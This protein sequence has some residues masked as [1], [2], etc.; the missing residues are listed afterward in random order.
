[1]LS[2]LEKYAEADAVLASALGETSLLEQGPLLRT[3]AK[4]QLALDQPLLAVQHYR[5]LLALMRAESKH[6]KPKVTLKS[7]HIL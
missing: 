1:M 7:L 2:A 6:G 5:A 4:L 3:R